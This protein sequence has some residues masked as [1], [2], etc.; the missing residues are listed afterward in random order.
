ML[1]HCN[2]VREFDGC[3]KWIMLACTVVHCTAFVL[4][5]LHGRSYQLPASTGGG[6]R[7]FSA[8]LMRSFRRVGLD[9]GICGGCGYTNRTDSF[10]SA[11]SVR[12]SLWFKGSENTQVKTILVTD[13]AS[14]S[15]V[16]LFFAGRGPAYSGP[17]RWDHIAVQCACPGKGIG[18]CVRCMLATCR[19]KEGLSRSEQLVGYF[20]SVPVL[21]VAYCMA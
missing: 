9:E 6:V 10:P 4:S 19:V 21:D 20:Y 17:Q 2:T 15:F 13:S 11:P 12:L 7:S 5:S 16:P 1:S 14:M 3:T 18:R 8:L